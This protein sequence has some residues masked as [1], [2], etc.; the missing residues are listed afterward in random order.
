MKDDLDLSE[1]EQVNG[2]IANAQRTLSM[3]LDEAGPANRDV[4]LL[5]FVRALMH[6]FP[7]GD[8]RIYFLSVVC[9]AAVSAR[10]LN[11]IRFQMCRVC[12]CTEYDGCLGKDGVCFW[13]AP[14]LCSACAR[15]ERV[16]VLG[17]G[18]QSHEESVGKAK[19]N[20]CPAVARPPVQ[21]DRG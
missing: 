8:R 17:E 2:L 13:F 10:D 21:G 1:I 4:L 12:G 18:E 5:A 16:I 20:L 19:A 11:M 9:G 15:I 14:G 3:A 6:A 7:P